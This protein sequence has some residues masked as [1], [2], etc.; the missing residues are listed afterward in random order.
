M[1]QNIPAARDN[2]RRTTRRSV[3][4]LFA[5]VALLGTIACGGADS[6]TSPADKNPAGIYGLRQVD[7]KKIP[8]EVFRD[9]Y[10]DPDLDVTFDPLV[11]QIT[12]GE[13][14]LSEDGTFHM[15]VDV[16]LIANGNEDRTSVT[17]D[18]TYEITGNKIVFQGAGGAVPGTLRNGDITL[19][20]D[21]QGQMR[22]YVF[23]YAP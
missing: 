22:R 13:V 11:V 7:G 16:A 1:T 23:R 17:G 3:A 15:A 6:A 12:G 19:E 10:Y 2:G 21:A 18:G 14:I 5:A 9:R 20:I 8:A 4:G